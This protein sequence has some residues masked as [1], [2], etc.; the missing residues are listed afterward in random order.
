MNNTPDALSYH[1]HK[2]ILL[3]GEADF[4]F[5]RAFAQEFGS[6]TIDNT[7]S[8]SSI[9]I[10]AT[11]VGNGPNI[12]S[13]YHDGNASSATQSI[14]SLNN[15]VKEV[16]CGLNARLLGDKEACAC[17][18]WNNAEQ[19]WDAPSL[20]WNNKK[21][22]AATDSTSSSSRT[23]SFDLIIFNFPHCEQAGRTKRLIRALFKQ[24]RI[25][26][27]DGRL[28]KNVVLEMRLRILESDPT[29]RKNIRSFYNH[30][31]AAE[32]S[33]FALIGCW[34]SDL[35][36]WEELGYAHK[37]TKKNATCRDIGL[38]CKVWRW[39]AEA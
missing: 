27:D 11:E 16:V 35:Q 22:D 2:R 32:E 31:E 28:P 19:D 9:E 21:A 3:L 6:N 13:R 25:C 38:L 8:T 24:L 34:P 36:R 1:S 4:S 15:L 17:Q 5:A 10:T 7:T 18:R 29:R 39:R 37:W 33:R 26:L 20:F 30:E 12:T 14:S 23:T